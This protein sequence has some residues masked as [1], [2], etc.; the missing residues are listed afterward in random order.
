MAFQVLSAKLPTG[1][2]P[3]CG[4]A[5]EPYVLLRRGDSTVTSDDVPEEGSDGL[6]QLRSRW[7]RSAVPKGGS[8][9][10]SV[11]PDKEATAQCIICLRLKVPVHLTYH[12][13]CE[14]MRNNWHLHKDYHKQYQSNGSKCHQ[15]HAVVLFHRASRC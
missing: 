4:V 6:Y 9:H 10:C 3:I 1:D 15:S 5:L 7:Y 8:L 13:S 14:C 12:C 2:T 11:H